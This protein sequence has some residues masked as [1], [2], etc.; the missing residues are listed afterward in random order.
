NEKE[1]DGIRFD[2]TAVNNNT[3]TATWQKFTGKPQTRTPLSVQHDDGGAFTV[4]TNAF[5][6]N[7][8]TSVNATLTKDD[9]LYIRTHEAQIMGFRFDL[10]GTLNTAEATLRLQRYN[11]DTSSWTSVSPLESQTETKGTNDMKPFAQ[12]GDILISPDAAT[13]QVTVNGT[14]GLWWRIT[15]SADLT[16]VTF[17]EIYTLTGW[18]NVSASDGTALSGATF[19]QDG[20]VTYTYA[21]DMQELRV[22]GARGLW[23]RMYPSATLDSVTI[24]EMYSLDLQAWELRLRDRVGGTTLWSVAANGSGSANPTISTP[25][26][27]LHFEFTAKAKQQGHGN[28]SVYAEIINLMVYKRNQRHHYVRDCKGL[29]GHIGR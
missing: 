5:D 11:A 27:T 7:A 12:D 15:P 2:F 28:R 13:S 8:G 20:D 1:I 19:G 14:A 6:A 25:R 24:S 18:E 29:C 4:L 9:Y 22:N 23:L 3:A 26:Q 16:A 21:A 17:N 10:G